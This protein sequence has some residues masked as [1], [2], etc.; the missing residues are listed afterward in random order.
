M[1]TV[2]LETV[3]LNPLKVILFLMLVATVELVVLAAVAPDSNS[4]PFTLILLTEVLSE[5][6]TTIVAVLVL[7]K[8]RLL[9]TALPGDEPILLAHSLAK[10]LLGFW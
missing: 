8:R 1:V 10:V 2:L 9:N 6:L 4:T 7:A 3:A 5:P